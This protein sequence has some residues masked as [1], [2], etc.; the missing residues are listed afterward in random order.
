MNVAPLREWIVMIGGIKILV[1]AHFL[2][3]C[4][5]V[6]FLFVHIYMATMGHTPFAHFKP[7][8]TGWEKV[9]HE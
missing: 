4:S 6:S 8:W 2:I 7:M 5:F 1:S 9:V 3:A